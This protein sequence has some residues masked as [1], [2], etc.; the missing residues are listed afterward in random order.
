MKKG[1]LCILLSLV[2]LAPLFTACQQEANLEG[3]AASVY[4]LYTI[5]DESTTDEAITQVELALNRILFYRLGVILKLEMVTEEEYD[6]LIEDKFEEMEAYQIEKKNKDKNKESSVADEDADTSEVIKTGDYI[7]DQLAEGNEIELENPRFDIFLVRGYDRYYELATTGKLASLDEKLNAE[8]KALKSSIH[9]TLFNAAKVNNKIYGVPVNNAIG[10][11][12]YLAFDKELLEKYEVDPNTIKSIED[13]QGYLETIKEN[14]PDVVPLKNTMQSDNISFLSNEG[15]PA[16]VSGK[17]EVRDAYS[18]TVLKQYLAMIARYKALGYISD[19]YTEE[20]DAEDTSRYAVRIETGNTIDIDKRLE[21]TGYEY[22]YSL[23]SNP[24]ATNETTIDNIFCISKYVVSNELTDVME[25]VNALNTDADLMNLLTYGVE[26]E[27]YILNDD[28]QV[29]RRT[30][31]PNNI[32]VIDPNHA[33]NA[34]ITHTL[35]GENPDKWNDAI[36]QNQDAIVSP[37]LGFT[38]SLTEFKYTEKTEIEDPDNPDEMIEEEV[39]VTV[40]EPDYVQIINK[41][42]DKYYPQLM[43]G[44]A[45]EFDY[46]AIVAAATDEIRDEFVKRLDTLYEEN[47]LK[48]MFAERI[49]E[50]IINN[51]SDEI[52]ELSRTSI[53][54]EYKSRVRS[55]LKNKLKSE[56]EAEH[57][58]ASSG[59]INEMINEVLT[60]EYVDEHI[61][62]YYDTAE[63]ENKVDEMFDTLLESEISQSTQAMVGSAEY[64]AQKAQLKNSADYDEDLQQM[65]EYDAP[66]K[67]QARV[68]EKIAEL[69][70]AYTDNMIA[71]MDADIETAVEEFITEYSEAIGLEREDILVKLGYLSKEE[72]VVEES[73]GEEAEEETDEEKEPEYVITENYESWFDFVF[74][75]KLTKTYYTIFGDPNAA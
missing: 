64:E 55:N 70:T 66:R 12:T 47:I 23:F 27:H 38:I 8:A 56:F 48:P 52:Y 1:I 45:V 14:E 63:I 68:D 20:S 74:Q 6:Q 67:I 5:V 25:I 59:E 10:E 22:D 54:N 50:Q 31:N 69:L 44:T 71:E 60:E 2:L 17:G 32:Y 24:V 30:D 49:R 65:L 75:E 51:R 61:S 21:S 4:T 11:Y 42:V 39:E 18:D 29:E 73:E 43:N 58:D 34:F 15:F 26:N 19:E 62:D 9:S 3:T 7:L 13:L 33:G 57:P 41:V 72:V 16:I 46:D 37:S 40:N 28:N 36:K 35:A 53:Y